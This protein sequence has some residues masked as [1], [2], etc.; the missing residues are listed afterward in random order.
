MDYETRYPEAIAL[1]KIETENVAEALLEMF[2]RVGIPPEI[3]TD[4]G[5]QFTSDLMS[6][7]RRLLSF[8]RLSITPYHP[9]YNGLVAKFNG[10][11]KSMLQQMCSERPKDWDWYLSSM[12]FAYTL[13]CHKSPWVFP[14]L[15]Y[16]MEEQYVALC[17]Y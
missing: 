4:L 2:S 14:P 6:E 13:K 10:M 16:C 8:N 11:L 17:P 7:V 5:T 12:L 1:P 9:I 3:L 15:N